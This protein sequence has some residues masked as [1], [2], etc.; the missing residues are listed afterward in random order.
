[1]SRE[2]RTAKKQR[3]LERQRQQI[4]QDSESGNNR[5]EDSS[6]KEH[7][8]KVIGFV[9][10]SIRSNRG[11]KLR[12][13]TNQLGIDHEKALSVLKRLE[14]L[15]IIS[16]QA[17][18]G[19]SYDISVSE[20]E[21]VELQILRYFAENPNEYIKAKQAAQA[22]KVEREVVEAFA[23]HLFDEGALVKENGRYG[24]NPI[25]W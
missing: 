8:P 6:Y 11:F 14:S 23:E 5:D 13:L 24:H 4:K 10:G 3:K 2:S 18:G 7:V 21:I 16:D 17:R 25:Y 15:G 1:M 12:G 22:M 9:L 19:G 20:E